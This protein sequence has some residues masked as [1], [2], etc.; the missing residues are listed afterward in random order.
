MTQ[1]NQFENTKPVLN[2]K[3]KSITETSYFKARFAFRI[4]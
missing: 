3:D 1:E 4:K 2:I